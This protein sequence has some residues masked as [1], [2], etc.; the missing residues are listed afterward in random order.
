MTI[1]PAYRLGQLIRLL[2]RKHVK[3]HELTILMVDVWWIFYFLAY[4]LGY[5]AQTALVESIRVDIPIVPLAFICATLLIC[6]ITRIV[7]QTL[8]TRKLTYFLHATWFCYLFIKTLV[9][10]GG[11]VLSTGL[12]C[13]LSI[14]C[15]I[16]VWRAGFEGDG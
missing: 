10:V 1:K 3:T 6:H 12:Y 14:T 11:M 2:N 13:A 15:V 16:L 8:I 5:A 7:E 9:A 4:N